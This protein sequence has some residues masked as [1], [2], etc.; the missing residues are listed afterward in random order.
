MRER[1]TGL[2]GWNRTETVDDDLGRSAADG[3]AREGFGRMIAD[4]CL[5]KIC[6][7]AASSIPC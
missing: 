2:V 1:V 3:I 6:A 7:V 4:V 5:G